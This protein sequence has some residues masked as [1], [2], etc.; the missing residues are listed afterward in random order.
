MNGAENN[1]SVVLFPRLDAPNKCV[2]YMV[3]VCV[4]TRTRA[5]TQYTNE[6]KRYVHKYKMCVC[7]CVQTPKKSTYFLSFDVWS[8]APQK[9]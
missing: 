8:A 2:A 5:H 4:Y 3:C 6:G 1:L 9:M 7:M